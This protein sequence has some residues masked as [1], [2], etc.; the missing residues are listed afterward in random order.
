MLD[1]QDA[2]YTVFLNGVKNG[3]KIQEILFMMF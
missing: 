2:M 1:E 3:N